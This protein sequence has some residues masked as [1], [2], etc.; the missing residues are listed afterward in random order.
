VPRKILTRKILTRKVLPIAVAATLISG[1]AIAQSEGQ[2]IVIE[3][4]G[5]SARQEGTVRV[6]ATINLFLPGPTGE[7]DEAIKSR[8]RARRLIYEMAG[9]ECDLLREVLARDCRLESINTQ[10]MR[11]GAQPTEGYSV[12]GSMSLQITLK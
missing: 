7:T 4:A 12:S 8:D 11:Q 5:P 3:R 1:A 10:L 2:R 9:K 6:Q